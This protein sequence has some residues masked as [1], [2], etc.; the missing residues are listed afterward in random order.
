MKIFFVLLFG[1]FFAPWAAAQGGNY[2]DHSIKLIVPFTPGGGADIAARYF[3]KR[4]GDALKQ[5]VVVINRPGAFGAI[6]AEAAKEAPADG[7]TL[8]LG[9]NSPMTVNPVVVKN[10][11]YD[12]VKD[13]TPISG[14]ARNTNVIIVPANSKFKTLADLVTAAKSA[15]QPLNGG[16]PATGYYL[17]MEWFAE[18]AGIKI[19]HIPYK[20]GVSCYTDV[21]AGRVDFGVAELAGTGQFIRSG[22]LRALAIF[23]EKRHSEFPD[24]PTVSESFPGVVTFSWNALFVRTQTP[25]AIKQKLADSMKKIMASKDAERFV[26]KVG[27]Q[28][29]PLGPDAMRKFQL[30]EIARFQ[31]IANA[32][33]IKP[34]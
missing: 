29:L 10:L 21:A 18:T 13:F 15:P 6:G 24:V 2:P 25:D 17:V 12:P 23:D 27:T 14:L 19:N 34:R 22:R 28:L 11:S 5:N 32:A 20:G 7:Y 31:R 30:E 3:G 16:T 8:L 9:S 1:L 4:L 33:G 26:H